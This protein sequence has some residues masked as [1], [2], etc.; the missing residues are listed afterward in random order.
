ML[1][2]K[3]L[4]ANKHAG[5]EESCTL[6]VIRTQKMG[7]AYGVPVVSTWKGAC[8]SR[9]NNHK[10]HG[11]PKGLTCQLS[12]SSMMLP[13]VSPSGIARLRFDI[14]SASISAASSVIA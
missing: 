7:C 13:L 10:D 12:L 2:V 1:P 4:L 11:G 3:A 14:S 9:G 6:A 8:R 5:W